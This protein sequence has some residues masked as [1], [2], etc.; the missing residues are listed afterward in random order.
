MG[1]TR[2]WAFVWA[3][4]VVGLLAGSGAVE[5]QSR[6]TAS[7]GA[8]GY[9]LSGTGWSGTA[10]LQFERDIKPWLRFEVGSG[11]FWYETQAKRQVTMLLPE[12]GLAIQSGSQVP[13]YLAAG[14]GRSFAIRGDQSD[15]MTLYG[16]LGLSLPAAGV[17]TFRPEMRVRFIDPFVGSVAG[18]TLG[19]SRS[20]ASQAR[21]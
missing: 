16:A 6:I 2:G 21:R 20:L 17:W 4:V 19:V 12:A 7:G 5:G 1:R 3:G 9:D 13:I 10:G 11:V 15:E 18:F 14:L 8:A